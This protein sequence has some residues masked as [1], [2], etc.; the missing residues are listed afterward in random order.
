[1]RGAIELAALAE[2]PT[3][4][5]PA[6]CWPVV[7]FAVLFDPLF[8]AIGR[9]R[10]QA[11]HCASVGS[12]APGASVAKCVGALAVPVAGGVFGPAVPAGLP[13]AVG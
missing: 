1:M 7:W 12:F 6:T 10:T 5:E 3:N 13:G 9:A 2:S 11:A 4:S 8:S